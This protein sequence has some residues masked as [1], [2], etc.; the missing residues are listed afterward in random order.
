M[1]DLTQDWKDGKLKT[2]MYYVGYKDGR[3]GRANLIL[4][5]DFYGFFNNCSLN[6][7][8]VEVL[9]EVP[10]YNLWMNLLYT[11]DMEHKANNRLLE[12]VERLEKENKELKKQVN[13]LSKTQARQFVDNQKLQV[14][15]EKAKDVVNLDTAKKIKQFKELLKDLQSEAIDALTA[16]QNDCES[17]NF[18]I[19]DYPEVQTFYTLSKKIDEELLKCSL[20]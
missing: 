2:G 13:H 6:D 14:K 17:D 1:T 12:D 5:P 9:D 19:F 4:T 3:Y 20:L 8:V 7:K 18:S 10:D 11:A 15:A 16:I